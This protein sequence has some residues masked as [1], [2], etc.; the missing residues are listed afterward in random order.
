[1]KVTII[2]KTNNEKKSNIELIKIGDYE[3]IQEVR[4]FDSNDI[5][6]TLYYFK[7]KND[8]KRKLRNLGWDR[9]QLTDYEKEFEINDD[10]NPS[11]FDSDDYLLKN[12]FIYKKNYVKCITT[13]IERDKLNI[14]KKNSIIGFR[15][16]TLYSK[17]YSETDSSKSNFVSELNYPFLK[18]IFTKLTFNEFD[19]NTFISDEF[20]IKVYPYTII[21]KIK[22]EIEDKF[23]RNI[24]KKY[25]T[26]KEISE[27]KM[28]P[29]FKEIEIYA[30]NNFRNKLEISLLDDISIRYT[31]DDLQIFSYSFS[32]D[33][34][35]DALL[36]IIKEASNSCGIHLDEL[37]KQRIEEL[38]NK[39]IKF[40]ADNKL[41]YLENFKIHKPESDVFKIILTSPIKFKG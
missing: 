6:A 24:P 33:I 5:Y 22:K 34:G 15:N 32:K 31:K 16:D 40:N 41:A 37:D 30:H 14:R 13:E 27:I 11:L 8:T 36:N 17:S 20:S 25:P 7:D 38:S 4:K 1:M 28:Y 18:T 12:N 23:F 9:I 39:Y 29:V 19:E 26:K 10:L 35:K 2:G 3:I 21:A